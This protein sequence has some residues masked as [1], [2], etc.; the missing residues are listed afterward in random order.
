MNADRKQV[1]HRGADPALSA[2]DVLGP[3]SEGFEGDGMQFSV[4]QAGKA[5][6][7]PGCDVLYFLFNDPAF[8]WHR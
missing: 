4:L 7:T 6:G 1:W 3:L 8:F 2:G 5:A